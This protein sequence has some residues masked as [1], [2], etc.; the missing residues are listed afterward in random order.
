MASPAVHDA[1][2]GQAWTDPAPARLRA[3]LGSAVRVRPV[4]VP[5][6]RTKLALSTWPRRLPTGRVP[7]GTSVPARGVPA[8]RLAQALAATV[9][10]V[11]AVWSAEGDT[12]AAPPEVS[13]A[14]TAGALVTGAAM[15]ATGAT[16]RD[17]A[18]SAVGPGG[19][20][21][22]LPAGA[23]VAA[24]SDAGLGVPSVGS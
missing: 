9:R 21:P 3:P 11:T 22:L 19:W 15:D 7:A 10:G 14:A 6:R 17:G 4:A 20:G 18:L 23:A 2:T 1:V 13:D 12:G 8:S 5:L 24:A 16:A